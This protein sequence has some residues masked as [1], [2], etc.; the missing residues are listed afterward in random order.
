MKFAESD[1]NSSEQN[2]E[3]SPKAPQRSDSSEM[4]SAEP[5]VD[6]ELAGSGDL[7]SEVN[8]LK[9]EVEVLKKWVR[10]TPSEKEL[11]REQRLTF[12]RPLAE[13]GAK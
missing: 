2:T 3:L 13:K 10:K 4:E 8:K 7:E 5:T 11:I 6:A 12:I 9:R 1:K